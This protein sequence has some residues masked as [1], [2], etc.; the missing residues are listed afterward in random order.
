[1]TF[2]FILPFFMFFNK[3]ENIYVSVMSV[4]QLIFHKNTLITTKYI[5]LKCTIIYFLLQIVY[6]DFIVRVKW[7]TPRIWMHYDL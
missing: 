2:R 4:S 6:N 7:H 1:M 5:I 3:I